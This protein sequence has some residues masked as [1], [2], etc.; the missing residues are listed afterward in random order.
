ML[1]VAS[2]RGG[3]TSLAICSMLIQ[4]INPPKIYCQSVKL[5]SLSNA[6]YRFLTAGAEDRN[7]VTVTDENNTELSRSSRI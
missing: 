3:S 2:K 6:P 5:R 4:I 7:V 1:V